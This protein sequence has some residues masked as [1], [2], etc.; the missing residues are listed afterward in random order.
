MNK[1]VLI[2]VLA[3]ALLSACGAP[4]QGARVVGELAS[5]R[6]ELSAESNEPI[7]EIAVAEGQAVTVGQVLVRQDI[8]R[9]AERLAQAE[10]VLAQQQA[11]LDE[12]VRGPRRE[13]IAAARASVEGAAQELAFRDSELVRVREVHKRGLASTELL[14]AAKASLDAAKANDKV[15]RARLEELLAGT[16]VEELRQAEQAVKQAAALRDGANIDLDRQTLRSPVDGIVDS[17]LFEIG[18]RPG[19]GQPVIIVLGGKQPYA[20]VYVPEDLRVRVSAGRR[21]LIYVD[22]LTAPVDGRVRWVSS[23]A[24]FTPYFALTER[25]RG[26]LSYVA[27]VDISED[28]ERLPDGVPVEVEFLVDSGS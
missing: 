16:T 20:R 4:K 7:V 10:A 11:R 1:Q 24:A 28:R 21:A 6:I 15:A 13:Q 3:C 2:A 22:G 17:R 26:R 8:T 9:A 14:D 25:D 18:E 12:L 27:K 19:S 5:D 23:E